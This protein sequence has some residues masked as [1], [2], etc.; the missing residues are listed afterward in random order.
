MVR[1]G[2]LDWMSAALI[3]AGDAKPGL[4]VEAVRSKVRELS[5]SLAGRQLE[6]L[7]PSEQAHAIGDHLYR[8]HGFR[9]CDGDRDD[10]RN[11]LLH[12]VIERRIGLPIVLALIYF[13]VAGRVGVAAEGVGFP[14]HFL[15][16]VTDLRRVAGVDRSVFVDP[17][18]GA[19]LE[20]Q[21]VGLLA[22]RVT[23]SPEV[24]P[25]WLLPASID[26][27][28]LRML[29]NL[30]SAHRLCGNLRG[31]LMVL[32]R[33]CELQPTAGGLLRDRGLLQAKLG[34]PRG[35]IVDL[36][37]YLHAMPHAS[38]V[39]EIQEM[40]DALRDRLHRGNA[41]DASN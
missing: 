19:V 28:A 10:P 18:G 27:I 33:M 41:A 12:E 15:L 25:N 11:S 32:H 36:E 39:Q 29:N 21:D 23:G 7:A 17:V 40:L 37:S 14:G 9:G 22:E 38:D 30:R 31:L 16:K 34:A 2:T 20:S 24:L 4:D 13:E 26:K 6:S 5:R 8:R 3:I 35:A 1:E